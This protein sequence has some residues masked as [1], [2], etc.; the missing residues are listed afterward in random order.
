MVSDSALSGPADSF[1][2]KVRNGVRFSS[3]F[4]WTQMLVVL[5]AGHRISLLQGGV[6]KVG[7]TYYREKVILL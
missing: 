2:I 7:T 4:A 1:L 6:V 5:V 3:G